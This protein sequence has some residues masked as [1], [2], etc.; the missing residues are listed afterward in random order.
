[1]ARSEFT[2]AKGPLARALRQVAEAGPGDVLTPV[3]AEAV[4]AALAAH[5]RPVRLS[6]GTLTVSADPEF[7][8][9]LEYEQQVLVTRLNARL[10]RNAVRK[11]SFM[12][13]V[14]SR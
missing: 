3:W 11:L 7:I 5:S 9:D 1:M 4:G 14:G 2:D 12:R 13:E 10:G 6:E 8:M